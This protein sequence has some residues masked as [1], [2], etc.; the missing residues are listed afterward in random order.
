MERFRVALNLGGAFN[1]PY[2]VVG[3]QALG[4]VAPAQ[5]KRVQLKALLSY[6]QSNFETGCFQAGGPLAPCYL[7]EP[8]L[9]E[10]L[11]AVGVQVGS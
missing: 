6:W 5:K 7:D 8:A 2:L 10:A 3:Q 9:L 1:P 11:L 4:V